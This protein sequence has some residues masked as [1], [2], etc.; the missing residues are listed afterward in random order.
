MDRG[1][2]ACGSPHAVY[3]DVGEDTCPRPR[4]RH[5]CTSMWARL[6]RGE[7]GLYLNASRARLSA[8]PT[9][10][11]CRLACALRMSAW[12]AGGGCALSSRYV[13]CACGR[14]AGQVE[15]GKNQGSWSQ[16]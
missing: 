8:M 2:N 4:T 5:S 3:E 10:M 13:L 12:S 14:G 7:A 16:E 11:C 6:Q 9:C 1:G 15:A